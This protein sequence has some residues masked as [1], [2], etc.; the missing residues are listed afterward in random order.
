M[1]SK[2]KQVLK[3][4][5]AARLAKDRADQRLVAVLLRQVQ[6]AATVRQLA[7]L[8]ALAARLLPVRLRRVL[9]LAVRAQVLALPAPLP[10]HQPRQGRTTGSRKST[11]SSKRTGRSTSKRRRA[12]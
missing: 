5:A 3:V 4:R 1:F 10:V 6:A 9:R 11:G 7:L 8:Q 2:L 12:R